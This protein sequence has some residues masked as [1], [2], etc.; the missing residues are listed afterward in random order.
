MLLLAFASI[1][2]CGYVDWS[3]FFCHGPR[4]VYSHLPHRQVYG[5]IFEDDVSMVE[6][7]QKDL[8]MEM[9][10][11]IMNTCKLYISNCETG[12]RCLSL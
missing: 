5:A 9:M 8:D 1:Q 10:L 3:V 4:L 11:E 2:V 6:K 7:T 12:R